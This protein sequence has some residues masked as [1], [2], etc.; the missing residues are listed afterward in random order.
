MRLACTCGLDMLGFDL[1]GPF[2]LIIDIS[3]KSCTHFSG[4]HDSRPNALF[5]S[6]TCLNFPLPMLTHLNTHTHAP[7]PQWIR[8]GPTYT[9]RTRPPPRGSNASLARTPARRHIGPS[10]FDVATPNRSAALCLLLAAGHW[11]AVCIGGVRRPS[12][13]LGPTQPCSSSIRT[14]R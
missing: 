10:L 14:E 5:S 1:C 7:P 9:L 4:V 12:H 11:R 6:P 8:A 13:R 3:V 2:H